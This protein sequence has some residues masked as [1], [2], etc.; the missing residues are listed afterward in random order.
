MSHRSMV[1]AIVIDVTV[2]QRPDE[3][4]FWSGAT[5]KDLIRLSYPGYPG[6]PRRLW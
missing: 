2:E 5:G 3:V 4:A 6:A 1:T